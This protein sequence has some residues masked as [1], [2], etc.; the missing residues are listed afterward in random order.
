MTERK[1]HEA[2]KA[3][4]LY[5]WI[6]Y[7]LKRMKSEILQELNYSAMQLASLYNQLKN[8]DGE[9]SSTITQEIRYGYRQNQSI[10]ETLSDSLTNLEEKLGALENL[11]NLVAEV[12]GLKENYAQLHA[13]YEE[14]A[15]LGLQTAPME[16]K[17][18]L[19]E[20]EYKR[21]SE[22][23]KDSVLIHSRQVLDA[24]AAIPVAENVDYTRIVDEVGDRLLEILTE[25]KALEVEIKKPTPV[26]VAETKIDYDRIIGGTV[27]KVVES[28]PYTEKIDYARIAQN[29]EKATATAL[30]SID[31]NALTSAVAG[32]IMIPTAPEIDYDRL[33]DLVV[34]KLSAKAKQ[35]YDVLLDDEGVD[36][37]ATKVAEKLCTQCTCNGAEEPAASAEETTADDEL[38]VSLAVAVEEEPALAPIN[39]ELVERVKKSFTAKLKQSEEDVKKY[40]SALK[41]ELIAYRKINSNV[42]WNGDRFNFGRDTVA[43]ITIVGKTLCFYLALDPNSAEFK[44]TEY[45]Q[46]DVGA[47]KKHEATPFM[48]K[49]KSELGTKKAVRLI[50]ALAQKLGAERTEDFAPV[51]FVAEYAY[52][53]D[54]VLEEAGHIKRT[55][56]KKVAFDF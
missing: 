36:A 46:K 42:S 39:E 7:D 1:K 18:E 43:K 25:L 19:S 44:Q 53:T 11:Q 10:F 52:E 55:Q 37:I 8:D 12:E 50:D 32:K 20:D 26:P 45:R 38:A 33:A 9:T 28:L 4:A 13:R 15:S 14:L 40:Y 5:Q 23:V 47:Q 3:D 35:T 24:V 48:I 41:N 17:D 51:D 21:I 6:S 31:I 49:I 29:A 16:I 2:P 30:A 34:E 54:E 56:E 22:I 27:E